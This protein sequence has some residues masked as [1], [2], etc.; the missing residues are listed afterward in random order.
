MGVFS[1]LQSKGRGR[2]WSL[3]KV[4]PH[5]TAQCDLTPHLVLLCA[6]PRTSQPRVVELALG[7]GLSGAQAQEESE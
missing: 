6:R 5:P 7:G 2:I 1:R 4:C 3:G